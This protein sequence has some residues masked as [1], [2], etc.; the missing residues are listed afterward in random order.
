MLTHA[1]LDVDDGPVLRWPRADEHIATAVCSQPFLL[2]SA[3]TRVTHQW[4]YSRP[5]IAVCDNTSDC[6]HARK[7]SSLNGSACCARRFTL[8]LRFI[9]RADLDTMSSTRERKQQLVINSACPKVGPVLVS[10]S[11]ISAMSAISLPIKIRCH[12][13]ERSRELTAQAAC[14]IPRGRDTRCHATR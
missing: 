7:P 10:L 12:R 14:L 13:E 8:L 4:Y 3:P 5:S 6:H 2:V 11:I 1:S 9:R